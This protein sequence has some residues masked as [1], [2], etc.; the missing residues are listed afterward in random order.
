MD[1]FEFK[2]C[3]LPKN[4]KLKTNK[5]DVK[6][7]HYQSQPRF[8]YGF[9]HYI[10]T[11]K[12]KCT[13]FNDPKYTTK[14]LVTNQFEQ[15]VNEYDKDIKNM[16]ELYFEVKK[17]SIISTA[18]YNLWE[19]LI[20]FDIIPIKAFTTVCL[21]DSQGAFAQAINYYRMKFNDEKDY[22]KDKYY[23]ISVNNA[24]EI[25]FK[26]DI[27][28]TLN[29]V[30]NCSTKKD[31]KN[32]TNEAELITA[33]GGFNWIN[34]KY[35]EQEV[36][37]L[38]LMEIIRAFRFQKKLGN[39]VLKIF[40]TF[41]PITLKL[42]LLLNNYYD[43][44]A[45]YKPFTSSFTKSEKYVI[46]KTFKGI[47]DT[48]LQKLETL[49]EN[50]NKN[51]M[52]DNYI[53]DIFL[54]YKLSDNIVDLNKKL[55]IDMTNKLFVAI[56]NTVSFLNNGIFFGDEYT[57]FHD[58]QIIANDFW[59]NTFLPIDNNDLKKVRKDI[60]KVVIYY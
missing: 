41:T 27:F 17:D 59:I 18:F 8:N 11:A 53:T 47:N 57:K 2:I 28:K 19:I 34:E 10:H 15:Q 24:K 44:V 50:I 32:I 3:K 54:D 4:E 46:C 37:R 30:T 55:S 16:S 26:N 49:L 33:D 5:Y 7:S 35:Q 42:L 25:T 39:F 56:N 36:Y 14:Y 40:D 60:N 1:N 21:A 20:I 6:F 51:E 29:N 58:K 23:C 31:I 38:I 13:I 22:S 48:E 45:I 12:E 43:E 9:H 52:K